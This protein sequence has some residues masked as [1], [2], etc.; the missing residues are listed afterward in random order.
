MRLPVHGDAR[1]RWPYDT[2]DGM[3]GRRH[4]LDASAQAADRAIERR[5]DRQLV[6]DLEHLKEQQANLARHADL[7]L[8][9]PSLWT[10]PIR[11]RERPF[12]PDKGDERVDVWRVGTLQD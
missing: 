5:A 11:T 10:E 4:H 1:S 7:I 6:L 9:L 3:A 12:F 8:V 2:F